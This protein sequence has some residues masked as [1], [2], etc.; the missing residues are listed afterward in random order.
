M[1]TFETMVPS[2]QVWDKSHHATL[3]FFAEK[4]NSSGMDWHFSRLYMRRLF[5][6]ERS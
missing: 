6:S 5:W 4:H 2:E 3:R 1:A